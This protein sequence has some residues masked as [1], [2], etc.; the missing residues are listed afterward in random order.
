MVGSPGDC[1]LNLNWS[2]CLT[3]RMHVSLSMLYD[4]MINLVLL[5]TYNL[6]PEIKQ[7]N[8]Q[9]KNQIRI[10]IIK[11]HTIM[12]KSLKYLYNYNNNQSN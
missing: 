9:F 2:N 12:A 7:I 10:I 4:C 5:G 6:F 11:N 3:Q 8:L 1:C